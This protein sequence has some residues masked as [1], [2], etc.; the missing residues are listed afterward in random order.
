[1]KI[2]R[3]SGYSADVANMYIPSD[4]PTYSLST[5]LSKQ[6]KWVDGKPTDTVTGYQAW[7]VAKGTEPFKVKFSNKIDLPPMLAKVKLHNLEA[8]EV[9]HNVYFKAHG[10]EVVK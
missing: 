2:K 3:S 1:M 7:F 6:V 9:G 10:I 4:V 5:E 8:C